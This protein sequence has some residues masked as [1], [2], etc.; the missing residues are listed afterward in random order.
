MV[1]TECH[2]G[3]FCVYTPKFC[4]EGYCPGCEI[5]LK[6]SSP[7]KLADRHVNVTLQKEV[8]INP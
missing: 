2:K 5:Y 1:N 7:T 8:A 3:S 6:T 4:Q